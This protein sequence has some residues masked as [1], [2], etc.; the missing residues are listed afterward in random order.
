MKKL[1]VA[2]LV[3]LMFSQASFGTGYPAGDDAS[4]KD[5]ETAAPAQPRSYSDTSVSGHNQALDYLEM[6]GMIGGTYLACRSD[7]MSREISNYSNTQAFSIL[8]TTGLVVITAFAGTVLGGVTGAV[9][10]GPV[11][12]D[13]M[14]ENKFSDQTRV[15]MTGLG[16]A[17][18][19]AGGY[20]GYR[21]GG[22]SPQKYGEGIL[23]GSL[24]G[25]IV[26]SYIGYCLGSVIFPDQ[27]RRKQAQYK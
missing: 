7:I 20:A 9:A 15:L 27:P 23:A 10:F 13:Y 18:M 25:A 16:A 26:G 4:K 5:A 24:L 6:L 21:V 22:N 11:S 2:A 14:Q 17:A 3:C 8:G 19:A 1:A 12:Q